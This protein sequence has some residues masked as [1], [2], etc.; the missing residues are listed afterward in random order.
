MRCMKS[1]DS[2]RKMPCGVVAE[3]G[4][5]WWRVVGVL[6]VWYRRVKRLGPTLRAFFRGPLS[7]P[8]RP[9]TPQSLPLTPPNSATGV[10]AL[11][12]TRRG[13]A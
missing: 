7:T 5:G 12:L 3:G 1:T 8:A 6:G 4:G 10:F 2:G 11:C 9:P 13:A